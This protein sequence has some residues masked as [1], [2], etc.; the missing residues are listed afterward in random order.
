MDMVEESQLIDRLKTVIDPEI[1]INIVDLN[2]VKDVTVRE[3]KVSVTIHLTVPQCPLAHTISEDV[4]RALGSL[5][6]VREVDVRTTPMSREELKEF[7]ERVQGLMKKRVLQSHRSL[8]IEKLDK[9]RIGCILAIIS[10]K[11]GVGKSFVTA[12]LAVELRRMGYTVGVLDADVTGPSMAKIFGL[13]KRLKA[14]RSSLKPAVTGSGIKVVSMNLILEDPEAAVIWRG[15]IVTKAISQLYTDVNWGALHYLL[16]D[17]PPGTSDVPLTIFQSI[18][19][20]GVIVVSTPQDLAF[21]IVGKALNMARKM[22]VPITGLIENMGY[23]VCK[24][25]GE[26]VE[27]FGPL[28]GPEAAKHAQIPFLGTIPMDPQI[29]YLSDRGQIED[30]RSPF[31]NEIA[32]KVRVSTVEIVSQP[33]TPIGWT[34]DKEP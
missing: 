18:P 21:M 8:P 1:G 19:L 10:G 27:L 4:R 30:Y 12:M 31:V 2:M 14:L 22:K 7:N 3:G 25:C 17:L 24:G 23:Y 6:G 9:G 11:G 20:D 33:T 32:R 16:I 29:P 5:E 34:V 26:R 13:K 15:L 28:K